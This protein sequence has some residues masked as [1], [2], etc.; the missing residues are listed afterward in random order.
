MAQA[1]TSKNGEPLENDVTK[2]VLTDQLEKEMPQPV[3]SVKTEL[4]T[5]QRD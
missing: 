2:T 3:A 5:H 1:G 4:G